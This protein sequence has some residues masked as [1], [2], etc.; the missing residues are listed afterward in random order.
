M[1][2]GGN[3]GKISALKRIFVFVGLFR[4]TAYP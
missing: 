4:C 2:I 1:R 3:T